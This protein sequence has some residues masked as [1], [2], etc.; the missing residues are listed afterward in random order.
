M[1]I[2]RLKIDSISKGRGVVLLR[3]AAEDQGTICAAETERV[4]QR[5]I[6]TGCDGFVWNVV[7]RASGIQLHNV[8]GR[9]Q[10]PMLHG[11]YG[12][13]GFQPSRAA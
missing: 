9:R 5:N 6:H 4:R 1:I 12:D 13:A 10:L 2:L 3:P 8:R 11:H 7:Q